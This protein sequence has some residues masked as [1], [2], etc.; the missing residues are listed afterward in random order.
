[1]STE[2]NNYVLMQDIDDD[3]D[4][5]HVTSFGL[6]FHTEEEAKEDDSSPG[7]TLLCMDL[8]KRS[9]TRELEQ[10]FWK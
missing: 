9:M 6:E 3:S 5:T 4:E 2:Q 1:M 7:A 10:V 8:S